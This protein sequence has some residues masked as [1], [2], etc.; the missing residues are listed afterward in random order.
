[1]SSYLLGAETAEEGR[2]MSHKPAPQSAITCVYE[3]K[4]AELLCNVSVT[5]CKTSTEHS[6][7]IALDRPSKENHYTCKIDLKNCQYWGKKGLKSFEIEGKHADV[8]WDFRQVKFS[9][10]PEPRSDYYVALVCDQ[11]IVLLLGDLKDDAYKR[12]RSKPC[13]EEATLLRKKENVYGKRLFCTKAMLNEGEK[14][15]DIVIENSISGLGEP[16]MW[17]SIEGMVM[18]RIMN[19]NWR[20]RGNETIV[21]NNVP[22]QI[23]WDVHDWLFNNS[24]SSSGSCHGLFIF[25]PST[26]EFYH[27]LYAWKIE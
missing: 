25:K 3:T 14:E 5:W 16:E 23:F 7:S 10:N 18:I 6:L 17:I 1:M 19:L 12:T 11:E 21:V 4:L 8:Y 9:N 27:F 2:A 20:F 26:I 13:L 22:L 15:H 24:D